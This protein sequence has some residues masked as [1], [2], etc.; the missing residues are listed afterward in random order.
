VL[1]CSRICIVVSVRILPSPGEDDDGPGNSQA[2]SDEDDFIPG[3]GSAVEQE[4]DDR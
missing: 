1:L 4:G 2:N 3:A